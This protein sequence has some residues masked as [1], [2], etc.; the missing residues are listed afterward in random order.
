M[1]RKHKIGLF[2]LIILLAMGFLI[3]S[4]FGGNSGYSVAVS[5]LLAKGAQLDGKYVVTQGKLVPGS[6]AWNGEQVSL[7]FTLADGQAEVP[8]IYNGT[9]P[10]NFDY[11]Q[12]EIIVKGTWNNREGMF[13]AQKVETKCP[14][15]YEAAE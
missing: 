13:Y 5:E 1:R 9:A 12:A 14:S 6:A 10:D 3:L 2:M 8:I 7:K 4:G 15:K 11:P